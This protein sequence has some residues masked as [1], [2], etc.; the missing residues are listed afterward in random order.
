MLRI[1]P[2]PGDGNQKK[3]AAYTEAALLAVC[4]FYIGYAAALPEKRFFKDLTQMPLKN[5][6]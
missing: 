4:L 5:H 2:E 3:G 6:E 1:E